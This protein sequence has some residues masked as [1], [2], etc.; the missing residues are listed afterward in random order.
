ML[1]IKRFIQNP[2]ATNLLMT[3]I[4]LWGTIAWF[5]IPRETFP[6]FEF[7]MIRISVVYPGSTPDEIEESIVTRIEE[8]ISQVSGIDGITSTSQEGVGSV[9]VKVKPGFDIRK[10]KDEIETQVG[11]INT[12]P[13]DAEKPS[14]VQIVRKQPAI[15]LGLHGDLSE[16]AL[17]IFADS[18]RDELL[19]LPQI[20]LVDYLDNKERE[21]SIEV[22]ESRLQMY[23]LS[24]SQVSEA[25]RR[26]SVNI[27]AGLIRSDG[28]EIMVR[29]IDQKYTGQQMKSIVLRANPDGS[30]LRLGEVAEIVDSFKDDNRKSLM[31]GV[32]TK[33]LRIYKTSGEDLIKIADAVKAYV[34]KSK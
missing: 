21:I 31:D 28:G 1:S 17:K 9:T 26:E 6:E 5:Q 18:I 25:I 10:V 2:V 27:P 29:T 14:I 3:I 15:L 32:N 24:F 12:F 34:K 20:T 11:L 7:D 8:R 23:G 30:Q 4:L 19:K 16:D 33:V 22:S 13:R